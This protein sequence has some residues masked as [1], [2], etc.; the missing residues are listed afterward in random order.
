[1]TEQ[2]EQKT[3]TGT[4]T[5]Y[6]SKRTSQNAA[7]TSKVVTDKKDNAVDLVPPTQPTAPVTPRVKLTTSSVH[8]PLTTQPLNQSTPTNLLPVKTRVSK[9]PTS[10]AK[11]IRKPVTVINHQQKTKSVPESAPTSNADPQSDAA[12][13]SVQSKSP[14]DLENCEIDEGFS[15]QLSQDASPTSSNPGT[16]S[17]IDVASDK[18]LFDTFISEWKTKGR[19]SLSLACEKRP[20]QLEQLE[21][22]IGARHKRG[23]GNIYIYIKSVLLY[24]LMNHLTGLLEKDGIL[25]FFTR[26]EMPSQLCLALLELNG[27]GFSVEECERQKHVMQAKLTALE[28]QAYSLAGHSFSLTSIDDIAQVRQAKQ[29]S[30]FKRNIR[31]LNYT[32]SLF[33]VLYFELH[34]PPNG[35]IGKLRP[36]HP[37]PGI[38]LEWRR[39]TNA[40]TKVVFPLQREKQHHSGLAMD[41]IYPTAQTHTATGKMFFANKHF[42]TQ[43]SLVTLTLLVQTV[44]GMIL[45]ADYSQLELRVLAHLSKDHRLIQV[46]NGG[47]DVFR[48]IAAEWK[49]VDPESVND[50]LRQQAKQTVKNCVKNGYVQ[51]LMGRRRYLPGITNAN[52]HVK[53]HAERQAVNT[54]VQ[55]SAADIVK[56]ATVNIEKQLRKTYPTAPL[57]HQHVPSGNIHNGPLVAHTVKKEMECA[58]KLYVKLKAK[59]KVGPSW[60]NLQDLDI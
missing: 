25:D 14:S 21:T 34:L 54:T 41:R 6:N 26:V 4:H 42:E 49:S 57:S 17:I 15:L 31:K 29:F 40:L 16:F 32:V 11:A 44:G 27:V 36:L 56:L 10:H 58:V 12:L 39:I 24:A 46:L 59:V 52:V 3:S 23:K 60:G 38:I 1:M 22:G 33:Q 48:C 13:S 30:I 51:T 37:L 43:F 5:V 8:S 28:S 53:S 35:D 20:H 19:Y 7:V 9:C 2:T 18:R 45:A 50:N 47:A 55:G